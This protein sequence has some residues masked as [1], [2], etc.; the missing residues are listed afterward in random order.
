MRRSVR[1][2]I[3]ALTAALLVT[4]SAIADDTT[5]PVEESPF[6]E[7]RVYFTPAETKAGNLGAFGVGALPSWDTTEPASVAT[8]AGGGYLGNPAAE[9]VFGDLTAES[10]PTFE[11]TFTGA[12]DSLAV[13]LY[14]FV[15]PTDVRQGIR[16]DVTI[17]GEM[18][19]RDGEAFDVPLRPGGQAA[20]QL[21]FAITGI[22]DVMEYWKMDNGPDTEH[23]I[24][25]AI[26]PFY[27]GDEALYVYNAAEAP[28]GIIF[29][30]SEENLRNRVLVQANG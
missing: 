17:D 6:V 15:N 26:V 30:A 19:H 10:G 7:Q 2:L 28:S 24:R 27:F 9:I 8:G 1:V 12:L 16:V 18:V 11:G 5:E 4:G 21:N 14:A 20:K 3:A 22:A 29:N 25:I 13:D 23:T